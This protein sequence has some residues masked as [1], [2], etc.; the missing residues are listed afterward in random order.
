MPR[1]L[2]GTMSGGGLS[3]DFNTAGLDLPPEVLEAARQLLAISSAPT[4]GE[5]GAAKTATESAFAPVQQQ[6]ASQQAPAD[7]PMPEVAGP[8]GSF[9]GLLSANL[10][11]QIDPALAR[12]T[13]NA[14]EDQRNNAREIGEFN[15]KQK[16]EFDQQHSTKE[17]DLAMSMTAQS[18]KMAQDAGD[19]RAATQKALQ[20][21]KIKAALE[22]QRLQIIEQGDTDRAILAEAGA[23]ERAKLREA[24]ENKRAGMREAGDNARQI[25]SETS[26][27]ERAL[28]G[29]GIDPKTNLPYPHGAG[30]AERAA[31]LR[32]GL[33]PNSQLK[34]NVVAD[35]EILAATTA[36]KNKKLAKEQG[37]ILS[38]NVYRIT[39]QRWHNDK[40]PIQ[41][42][43][44]LIHAYHPLYPPQPSKRRYLITDEPVFKRGPKGKWIEDPEAR[45][46]AKNVALGL[47]E[48]W[49]EDE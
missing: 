2:Q 3:A 13:Y 6:L 19:D 44:R 25:S 14:L 43:E 21:E 17:L 40:T 28:I 23:D 24:G 16:A 22:K 10:A 39:T 4:P 8:L 38:Q 29:A 33:D 9:L 12:P 7:I 46:R 35:R 37:D 42:G 45:K 32:Q 34:L 47:T 5:Q 30:K 1:N 11:G 27:R 48:P 36:L 49:F 20:L 41:M 15:R 26:A 18:L 31:A